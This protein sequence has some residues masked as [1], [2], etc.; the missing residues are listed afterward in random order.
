MYFMSM[1]IKSV[2]GCLFCI[3]FLSFHKFLMRENDVTP[4]NAV[5]MKTDQ[6]NM[7]PR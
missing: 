7:T 3:S 6:I 2:V 1:I 5:E 4:S